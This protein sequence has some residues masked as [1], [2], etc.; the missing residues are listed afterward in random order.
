[1]GG[2]EVRA[3]VAILNVRIH[4]VLFFNLAATEFLFVRLCGLSDHVSFVEKTDPMFP[5]TEEVRRSIFS[6]DVPD[7]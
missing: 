6:M 2:H 4:H 5:L 3:R 1:M 7:L